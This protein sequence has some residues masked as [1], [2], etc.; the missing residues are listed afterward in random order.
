MCRADT[1]WL[2]SANEAE[3][4][5]TEWTWPILVC[6]F[7]PKKLGGGGEVTLPHFKYEMLE[8]ILDIA[9]CLLYY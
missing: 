5:L 9:S 2:V 4:P 7:A 8:S 3:L 6:L 1:P